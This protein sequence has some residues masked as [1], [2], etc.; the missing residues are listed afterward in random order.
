MSI[1]ANFG[2][3]FNKI[4]SPST[5]RISQQNMHTYTQRQKNILHKDDSMALPLAQD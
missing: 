4:S 2:G 1:Q 3:I 5:T